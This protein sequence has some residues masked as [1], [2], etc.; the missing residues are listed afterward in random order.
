MVFV[1]EGDICHDILNIDP[2]NQRAL[3]TLLLALSEQ[4]ENSLYPAYEKAMDILFGLKD[5]C[6]YGWP[7]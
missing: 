7:Q 4:F 2:E 1:K 5:D 3:K 6:H